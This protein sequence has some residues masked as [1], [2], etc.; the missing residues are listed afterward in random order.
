MKKI[1][2]CV[3]DSEVQP[4]VTAL[5]KTG[6]GGVTVCPV[7][8]TMKKVEIVALDI[9]TDFVVGTILEI[10]HKRK[11][12]DDAITIFPVEEV[13]RIRTGERGAKAVF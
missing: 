3:Q 2:C 12:S 1:E 7:K 6:I 9:E 11:I 13:I 8:G 5:V 4:L 10:T